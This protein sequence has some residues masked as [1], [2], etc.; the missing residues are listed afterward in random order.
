VHQ[1]RHAAGVIRARSPRLADAAVTALYRL[2]PELE[3]RYGEGGRRHCQKDLG[4]HL[5][6]LAAAV[7]MQDAKVFSD[8]ALWAAGVMVAHGVDVEDTLASFHA[9]A[10]VPA[11]MQPESADVVRAILTAALSRLDAWRPSAQVSRSRYRRTAGP[12]APSNAPPAPPSA[13]GSTPGRS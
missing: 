6:F 10:G 3:T 1:S 4:H 13:A 12:S 11:A 8:Y 9:L 5:R 2:R 7:E